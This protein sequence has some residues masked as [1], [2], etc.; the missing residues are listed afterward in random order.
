LLRQDLGLGSPAQ[1]SSSGKPG[2]P[3]YS[4][5]ASSSRRRP[6]HDSAAL[7]KFIAQPVPSC[8]CFFFFPLV[9]TSDCSFN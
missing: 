3:Y 2:T 7:G 5:S 8:E 9:Y 1:L 4:F 6:L